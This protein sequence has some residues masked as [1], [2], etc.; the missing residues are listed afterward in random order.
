MIF[1]KFKKVFDIALTI[2][3]F[4]KYLPKFLA[5]NSGS[6]VYFNVFFRFCNVYKMKNYHMDDSEE[7]IKN[8]YIHVI[9]RRENDLKNDEIY[10]ILHDYDK[11][12]ELFNLFK[13]CF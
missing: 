9:P 8:F 3:L 2:K 6:T 11:E 12:Y 7:L 4:A 13:K 10:D 1:F 5:T